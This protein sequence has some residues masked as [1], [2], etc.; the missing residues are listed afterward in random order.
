M[1]RMI[2][3]CA[4]ALEKS[5]ITLAINAGGKIFEFLF[6]VFCYLSLS[7]IF[8]LPNNAIKPF[9]SALKLDQNKLTCFVPSEHI[10]GKT[11]HLP[12]WS[13]PNATWLCMSTHKCKTWVKIIARC[14]RSSLLCRRV[15]DW[16]KRLYESD[17]R[18]AT[19]FLASTTT[20]LAT[21]S[22]CLNKFRPKT[23]RNLWIIWNDFHDRYLS[24]HF[25]FGLWT[26]GPFLA[27]QPL[28]V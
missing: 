20:P 17:A 15:V 25:G 19:S 11:I 23:F 13:T 26:F 2:Y 9:S 4:T 5:F 12:E 24:F 8:L 22:K 7:L 27:G 18:L 6:L 3:H 28:I 14:Q 1:S 10:R 21:S 16:E